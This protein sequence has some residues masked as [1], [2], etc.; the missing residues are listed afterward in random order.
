MWYLMRSMKSNKPKE[1]AEVRITDGVWKPISAILHR[2]SG[3]MWFFLYFLCIPSSHFFF[4]SF[5]LGTISTAQC[6]YLIFVFVQWRY[7]IV[8]YYYSRNTPTSINGWAVTMLDCTTTL[9]LPRTKWNCS[10]CCSVTVGQ[11]WKAGI[12]HSCAAI[13]WRFLG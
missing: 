1:T 3:L 12:G 7:Y 10:F 11:F 9:T 2:G 13:S 6:Y 8:Q 4:F 5:S